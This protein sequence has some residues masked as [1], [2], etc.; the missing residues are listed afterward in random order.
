MLELRKVISG[1]QTGA[2]QAG[3]VVAAR[4][5]LETGGTMPK[6]FKTLDGGRPDLAR[7]YGLSEHASDSYVPRTF[8]NA[9][10]GDGTVRL[11]GKFSSRGEVC[12]LQA[13]RKYDKPCFDVDLSDPPPVADFLN[14]L[15][16]KKVK[17]LNVAGNAEQTFAG[18]FRLACKYLT[19]TLF[20]AGLE[21]KLT[22]ED[23][24]SACGL[25]PQK[26]IMYT[27]DRTL[28]THLTVRKIGV[29]RK[30]S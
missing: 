22:D 18:S 30:Q 20:D 4:F 2:D 26:Q 19:E 9:M 10:D 12:T 3:L 15:V 6:G 27:D 24:L 23:I 29:R 11:A 28:V 7:R 14:W 13:C 17:V 1:G 16:E 8:Q 25:D 21:M 5:G